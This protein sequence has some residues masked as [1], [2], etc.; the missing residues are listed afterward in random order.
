MNELMLHTEHRL[1]IET[2]NTRRYRRHR[3]R[4]PCGWQGPWRETEREASGD[5]GAHLADVQIDHHMNAD[6]MTIT[7]PRGLVEALQHQTQCDPDGTN[8]IV[9][10]EAVDEAIGILQAVPQMQKDVD[11]FRSA[12]RQWEMAM[13]DAIG[14]DGPKSVADAIHKMQGE[15]DKSRDDYEQAMHRVSQLES[16]CEKA[17]TALLV[18]QTRRAE[19]EAQNAKLRDDVKRLI[20]FVAIQGIELRDGADVVDRSTECWRSLPNHLQDAINTLTER[21][22]DDE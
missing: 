18:E 9:S 20:E 17:E 13:M 8:C 6:N 7:V 11:M 21:L 15:L 12:E 19:M 1:S 2:N 4:C 16:Q 22:D 14:E 10:R 5:L 3:G